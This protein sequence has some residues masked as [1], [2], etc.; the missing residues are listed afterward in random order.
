MYRKDL[1]EH[2]SALS[3][4][5]LLALAAQAGQACKSPKHWPS[6]DCLSYGNKICVAT[7]IP[8][9]R[10]QK[11]TVKGEHQLV[12]ILWHPLRRALYRYCHDLMPAKSWA[13]PT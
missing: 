3:L 2:V 10:C 5:H 1:K 4:A 8:E 13:V 11:R 9:Q 12:I 7:E 6:T